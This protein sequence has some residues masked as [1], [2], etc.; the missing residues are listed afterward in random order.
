MNPFYIITAITSLVAAVFGGAVVADHEQNAP[1]VVNDEII[2]GIHS[3]AG[4]INN[5]M[6]NMLAGYANP[7]DV[8]YEIQLSYRDALHDT[9]YSKDEVQENENYKDYL[10][11]A[12][13]VTQDKLSGSSDLEKDV[14]IMN[15]KYNSI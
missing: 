13:T 7:A 15:D 2:K 6:Q 8:Q 1:I 3:N 11:A 4:S 12:Y 9:D 10:N 14:G 5:A